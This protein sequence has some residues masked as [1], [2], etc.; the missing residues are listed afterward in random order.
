MPH[1][2]A[3][4]CTC[5][6][7]AWESS[8]FLSL[9]AN[10]TALIL[11]PPMDQNISPRALN[12]PL[13]VWKSFIWDRDFMKG[14]FWVLHLV[15]DTRADET[16]QC[17]GF[18]DLSKKRRSPWAQLHLLWT[19]L[20]TSPGLCTHSR[21]CE[22]LALVPSEPPLYLVR[23][24]LWLKMPEGFVHRYKDVQTHNQERSQ[25][26]MGHL[27]S[28]TFHPRGRQRFPPSLPPHFLHWVSVTAKLP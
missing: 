12:N 1:T 24:E 26:Q 28:M 3:H 25:P 6:L 21:D 18:A 7:H 23:Y 20:W 9:D 14:Q 22:D 13:R 17:T 27:V 19:T 8:G 5:S 2:H 16:L 10:Q 11:R 15:S 4:A